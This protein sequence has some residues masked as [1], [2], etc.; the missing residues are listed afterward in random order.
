M[1]QPYCDRRRRWRS[2]RFSPH[3]SEYTNIRKYIMSE[4]IFGRKCK[5]QRLKKPQNYKMIRKA[6]K[7]VSSKKRKYKQSIT[8]KVSQTHKSQREFWQLLDKLSAKKEK[9]SSYVSQ[10]ALINHF[11]TLL[12]TI[13]PIDIL[14]RGPTWWQ[15]Y[16]RRA[17]K[18]IK[19]TQATKSGGNQQHKQWDAGLLGRYLWCCGVP[20]VLYL[21]F[22]DKINWNCKTKSKKVTVCS[23]PT[24]S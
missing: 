8:D 23:V 21:R 4:G 13:N 24:V 9:I 20:L 16:L 7:K 17:H 14:P 3:P 2:K 18:G 1:P 6:W 10:K 11:K 19:D 15:N 22:R 5:V 12:N